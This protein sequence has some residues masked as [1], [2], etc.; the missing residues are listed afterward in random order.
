MTP[1]EIHCPTSLKIKFLFHSELDWGARTGYCDPGLFELINDV[2][3]SIRCDTQWVEGVNNIIKNILK[4]CP[5]ISW[6]LLSDRVKNNRLTRGIPSDLVDDLIEACVAT[7]EHIEIDTNNERYDLF[8]EALAQDKAEVAAYSKPF[9]FRAPGPTQEAEH[10][11][12]IACALKKQFFLQPSY[13]DAI[14]FTPVGAAAEA[15][16]S[17]LW[18]PVYKYKTKLW[19]SEWKEYG[20]PPSMH[21]T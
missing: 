18:V 6:K 4:R 10:A 13:V 15:I 3:H 21:S 7:H 14:R 2:M 11:A 12:T 16:D 5:G 9:P 1:E 20:R 19:W 8:K 17:E